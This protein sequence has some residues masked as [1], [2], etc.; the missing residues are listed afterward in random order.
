MFHSLFKQCHQ[1]LTEDVSPVYPNVIP[2]HLQTTARIM[3]E[4]IFRV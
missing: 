4:I 3:N 2:P 1:E